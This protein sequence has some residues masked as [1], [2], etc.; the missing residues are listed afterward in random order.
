MKD[1]CPV[2][3]MDRNDEHE[4]DGTYMC[5]CHECDH[6]GKIMPKHDDDFVCDDCKKKGL[7]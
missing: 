4:R 2:C 3:H 1:I 5:W 6:C 7:E